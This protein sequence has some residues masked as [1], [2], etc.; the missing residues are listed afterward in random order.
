MGKIMKKMNERE[1]S[2]M[3]SE[4]SK[5]QKETFYILSIVEC[6]KLRSKYLRFWH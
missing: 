1:I 3:V 4:I 2:D 6:I 5:S